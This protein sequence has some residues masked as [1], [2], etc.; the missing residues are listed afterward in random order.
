MLHGA[1]GSVRGGGE[2]EDALPEGAHL[3]E[4][5]RTPEGKGED[6]EASA[7]S[8]PARKREGA[9]D[10]E[11]QTDVRAK[12]PPGPGHDP[13]P[14]ESSAQKSPRQEAEKI[15]F[16]FFSFLNSVLYV[17]QLCVTGGK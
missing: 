8:G 14:E 6:H 12:D 2:G 5:Q 9:A 1:E 16:F 15:D 3:G 11:P 7:A 4:S 17:N 10:P 13:G